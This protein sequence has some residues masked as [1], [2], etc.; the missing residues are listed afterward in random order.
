MIAYLE[1][2][3]GRPVEIRSAPNFKVYIERAIKGEYDI[4]HAAPHISAYMER[5]HQAQRVSSFTRK[6]KGHFVVH[7]NSPYQSLADFKGK[8]FAYP[9]PLAVIT[10]LGEEMLLNEGL[11]PDRD[12]VRHFTTH[13]NAM[14]LVAK[15]E[16]D[17]TVVG[18]TIYD[19]MPEV[20]KKNLRVLKSTNSIPHMMF[21]ARKDLAKE[22]VEALS[23]AML[24]FTKEGPGNVFFSRVAFGDM[25][26][27]N[28][29]KIKELTRLA[30]LLKNKLGT[31]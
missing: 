28:D 11:D 8:R 14:I 31:Q 21:H 16:Q 7:R 29:Q 13:N 26:E 1:Q 9:D 17:I 10:L 24:A 25:E 23:A 12:F 3:L 4:F 2:T 6:L 5:E 18:I 30:D 15:G 27:I 20:V 22:D 19:N